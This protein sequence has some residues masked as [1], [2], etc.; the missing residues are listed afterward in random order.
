ML[1]KVFDAAGKGTR[2][3]YERAM[4]RN[5]N[6][7][8]FSTPAG[9]LPCKEIFFVNWQPDENK[10]LLRQSVVDFVWNVLMNVNAQGHRSMALPAIGCGR[11]ACSVNV[12][13]STLVSEVKKQIKQRKLTVK[14]RFVIQPDHQNVY[15]EFHK[16][17]LMSDEGKIERS[18][19]P[20]YR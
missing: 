18:A 3:A 20:S 5:A 15:D 10:E 4:R 19:L 2:Q 1:E 8:L 7:L 14:V 17:I 6:S 13:V 16:Q 11:F 9:D 12:V